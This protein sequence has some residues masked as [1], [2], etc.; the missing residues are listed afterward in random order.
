MNRRECF[1]LQKKMTHQLGGKNKTE[2]DKKG[3]A[4]ALNA[5]PKYWI[6][7]AREHFF[8]HLIQKKNK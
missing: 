3:K 7:V 6:S 8:F 2:L 1:H 4:N 5:K